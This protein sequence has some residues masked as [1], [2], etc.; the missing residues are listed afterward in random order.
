[1]AP[2]TRSQYAGPSGSFACWQKMVTTGRL[3]GCTKTMLRGA[4]SPAA[5]RSAPPGWKAAC[6]GGRCAVQL[7]GAKLRRLP[8]L[9]GRQ[10]LLALQKIEEFLHHAELPVHRHDAGP[11][12]HCICNCTG[13]RSIIAA[14]ERQMNKYTSFTWQQ[15]EHCRHAPGRQ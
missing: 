5:G 7:P 1:M 10:P 11:W 14:Y 12:Y 13:L 8:C 3:P 2:L 9:E 15:R 4:P 6:P